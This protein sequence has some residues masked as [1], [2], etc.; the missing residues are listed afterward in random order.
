MPC[1]AFIVCNVLW[2]MEPESP[3][4]MSSFGDN[5]VYSDPIWSCHGLKRWCRDINGLYPCRNSQEK[6]FL[7][8][9][10]LFQQV[11]LSKRERSQNIHH[12]YWVFTATSEWDC[13]RQK[14]SSA[15]WW[16]SQEEAPGIG[17]RW[18]N[19][20]HILAKAAALINWS[21]FCLHGR[22]LQLLWCIWVRFCF[23]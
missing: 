4:Q 21:C 20:A 15:H 14:S 17:S 16:F 2:Q 6:V 22:A 18:S 10:V 3:R 19:E 8:I 1:I 23:F 9:R 7:L 11:P 5:K 13:R 12:V